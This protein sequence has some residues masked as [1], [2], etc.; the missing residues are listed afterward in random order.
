MDYRQEGGNLGQ[1]EIYF[2]I[3]TRRLL[4]LKGKG[5]NKS[6]FPLTTRW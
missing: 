2:L 3:I 6:F 5:I 1:G 4:L